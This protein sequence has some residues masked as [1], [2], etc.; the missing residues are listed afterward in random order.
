MLDNFG[1]GEFFFLALLALLFFGPERLPQIGAKFG[2]WVAGLTQY[3]KAFLTEWREEALA[4][5][6]AVEE[7]KGIRDEIVAARAELSST[8]DT[9]REDLTEGVDAAKEAVSGARLDVTQRLQEQQQQTVADL[10]QMAE[11]ERGEVTPDGAGEQEA[12]ERTQQIL[13]GLVKRRQDAVVAEAGDD[14]AGAETPAEG[15][16]D[17]LLEEDESKATVPPQSST[18]QVGAGVVETETEEAPEQPKV[19]PYE[20]TQRILEELK[21]KR[22]G[23]VVEGPAVASGEPEPSAVVSTQEGEAQGKEPEQEEPSRPKT[24]AAF[25]R[26]QEILQGLIKKRKSEAE[27]AAT[28]E[29]IASVDEAQVTSIDPA[30]FEQL[31]VQVAQLRDEMAALRQ[32]V[33]ALRAAAVRVDETADELP[34]EEAA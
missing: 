9:A 18:E 29:A 31:S 25:D 10:E 13:D 14:G 16:H 3:S 21:Q 17:L 22:S 19:T 4:I 12:I 24:A 30:E 2:R 32:E 8:L 27:P 23:V 5:H 20:R 11:G 1:L 7:V 26:T 33:Q 6:E 15:G 28:V 34:V